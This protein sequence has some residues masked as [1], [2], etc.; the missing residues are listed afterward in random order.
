[1][2][3]NLSIIDKEQGFEIEAQYQDLIIVGGNDEE[4]VTFEL[5]LEYEEK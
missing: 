4:L 2:D 3:Q 5:I 1:M